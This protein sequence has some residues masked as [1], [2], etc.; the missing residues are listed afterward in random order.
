MEYFTPI[1]PPFETHQETTHRSTIYL[2]SRTAS[3]SAA[4]PCDRDARAPVSLDVGFSAA[5]V[6]KMD[7]KPV[8]AGGSICAEEDEEAE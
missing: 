6:P 4:E 2:P 7:E 8:L 3:R 1:Q 5:V